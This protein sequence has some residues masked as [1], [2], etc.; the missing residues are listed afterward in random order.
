MTPPHYDLEMTAALRLIGADGCPGGWIVA[1]E[2]AD[3]SISLDRWPTN[4]LGAVSRRSTVLVAVLDIPMGLTRQGPRACDREARTL[5]G[6]PRRNAV[7]PAPLR[8]MLVAETYPEAQRIR[9]RIEGKGCTRQAFGILPK[10]RDV[11]QLL[12]REGTDKFH[13]AH[14]E[15]IFRELAQ[16]GPLPASKHTRE[17]R[18]QRWELLRAEFPGLPEPDLK[19]RAS[20]DALDAYACL[21]T[22]RRIAAGRAKWIPDQDQLDPL[23]QLPMRI[24]Y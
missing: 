21:W 17:G 20:E 18:E 23:L 10:V 11:D 6:W 22:A 5:L 15:L 1:L 14:P 7:F 4:H 24:W 13:E 8:P 3:G 12:G 16:G 2:L 19:R 9:H